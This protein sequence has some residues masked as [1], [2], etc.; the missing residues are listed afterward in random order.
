V[1]KRNLIV[2]LLVLLSFMGGTYFGIRLQRNLTKAFAPIAMFGQWFMA[3]EYAQI[4][5]REAS[6]PEAQKALESYIRFLDAVKTRA[7]VAPNDA[8]FLGNDRAINLDKMLAWSRLAMLHET[9]G[10]VQ[11][12]ESAWQQAESLAGQVSWKQSNRDYLRGAVQ[13]LDRA[14]AARGNNVGS[15][16]ESNS[17]SAPTAR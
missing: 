9:N 1:L 4:Q 6:Y 13:H 16:V 12:A 14:P 11:A 3:G 7:R 15:G 5:Y 10:N 8:D 2:V 17:N